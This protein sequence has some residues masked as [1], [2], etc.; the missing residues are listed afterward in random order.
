MTPSP[1]V[2]LI[3]IVLIFFIMYF[4]IIRPQAKQQK[5][6]EKMQSNLKKHD[7]VVTTGGIHGTILNVKEETLTLRVDDNARIEVDKTAIARL[8][9]E[10]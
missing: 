10:G 3:P 1:V 4:L 5:A 6:V 2:N 8:V 7:E 9:K